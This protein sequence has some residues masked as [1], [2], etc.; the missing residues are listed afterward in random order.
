MFVR[1]NSLCI[2][3]F[4]KFNNVFIYYIIVLLTSTGP[5]YKHTVVTEIF[6]AISKVLAIFRY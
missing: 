1:Y 3:M 4:V 2:L 6:K 5:Y